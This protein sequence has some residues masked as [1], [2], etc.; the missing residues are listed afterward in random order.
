MK[1]MLCIAL[2]MTLALLILTTSKLYSSGPNLRDVVVFQTFAGVAFLEKSTGKIY[3][4]DS[5]LKKCIG[6]K[7]LGQLGEPIEDKSGKKFKVIY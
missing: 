3:I 2:I 6:I 5:N 1:K 4:Y 7:M